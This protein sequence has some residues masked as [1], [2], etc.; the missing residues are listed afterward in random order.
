MV[1]VEDSPV[2]VVAADRADVRVTRWF[3]GIAYGG[4]TGARW[5]MEGGRLSLG[6]ACSGPVSCGIRHRVEVPRGGEDAPAIT[7][8]TANGHVTVRPASR[9][10]RS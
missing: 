5:S 1:D 9:R 3:D 7:A 8:R 10:D 6:P 2:E 4:S